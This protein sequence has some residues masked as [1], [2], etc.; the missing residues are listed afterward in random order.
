MEVG[1]SNSLCE[2]CLCIEL[3]GV[4][5]GTT[6]TPLIIR[7][8]LPC[9]CII[10]LIRYRIIRGKLEEEVIAKPFGVARALVGA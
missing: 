8:E 9:S 7:N 10:D 5:K 6:Y 4:A 1:E 3:K 2:M